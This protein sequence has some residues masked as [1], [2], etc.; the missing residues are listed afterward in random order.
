MTLAGEH[1]NV[2]FEDLIVEIV[3]FDFFEK[4]HEGVF[5]VGPALLNVNER[6]AYHHQFPLIYILL[7]LNPHL[8]IDVNNT[9]F[10]G[11]VF[12]LGTALL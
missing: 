2:F 8:A 9:Y 4:A 11:K 10:R 7:G 5:E 6:S 12:S 3:V 1:V